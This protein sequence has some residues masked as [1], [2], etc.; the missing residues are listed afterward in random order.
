MATFIGGRQSCKASSFFPRSRSRRVALDAVQG[1]AGSQNGG[2]AS[3]R[4][5]PLLALNSF[6]GSTSDTLTQCRS[7]EQNE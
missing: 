6:S 7:G 1:V 4:D 2:T 5:T 3:H